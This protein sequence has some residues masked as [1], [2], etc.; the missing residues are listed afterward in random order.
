MIFLKKILGSSLKSSKADRPP[1]GVLERDAV[2]VAEVDVNAA[3][4]ETNANNEVVPLNLEESQVN[5][6]AGVENTMNVNQQV[7]VQFSNINGL[8]IGSTYNISSSGNTA[9]KMVPNVEKGKKLKSKYPKTIT[10]EEMMKSQDE[11]SNR[12]L[13][14]IATHLGNDYK[15]FMRELGFSEGQMSAMYLDH[16]AYGIR[17]VHIFQFLYLKLL[18]YSI[19]FLIMIMSMYSYCT[20][21]FLI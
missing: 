2:K 12:I 3:G 20:H 19:T 14:E 8:Q 16:S 9:D 4:G 11:L 21:K 18:Q 17:E 15:M 1:E 6:Q 10:I 13:T 7:V 5:Q